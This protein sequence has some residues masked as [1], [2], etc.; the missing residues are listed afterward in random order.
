MAKSVIYDFS[1]TGN[2]LS[3]AKSVERGSAK[4]VR[5][6]K[7]L[8]QQADRVS[9]S[10]T[11]VGKR[12]I[13][14][15]RSL[16]AMSL[17]A[18]ASVVASAKSFGDFESG[19]IDVI[20][21]VDTADVGKFS[22]SLEELSK[23][24]LRMGFVIGDA[25]KGLFD[26]VSAL[27]AGERSF[28][29][30]EAS[31]RLAIA[32]S[33]ELTTAV[34]GMT[35]AVG[36][37]GD[38]AGTST[39]IANAFFAAQV[40]GKLDVAGLAKNIG[41]VGA[42]GKL[43]GFEFRPLLAAVSAIT[44]QGL[45]AEVAATGLASGINALLKPE[46]QAAIL[47][48]QN[49]IAFGASALQR[50]DLV[51]VMERIAQVAKDNPD[52]MAKM[53]PQEALKVM[54]AINTDSLETM[55]EALALMKTNQLGP[56]EA[57]KMDTFN[58]SMKQTF[59]SIKILAITIGSSLAPVIKFFGRVIQ[60]VTAIFDTFSDTTKSVFSF[61]L[62]GAAGLSTLFLVIGKGALV[63]ATWGKVLAGLGNLLGALA[64][65]AKFLFAMLVGFIGFWPAVIALAVAGIVA[66]GVLIHTKGEEMLAFGK[67]IA[68]IFGFGDSS[69]EVAG[70]DALEAQPN[71]EVTGV[72]DIAS[73]TT[74]EGE[75]TVKAEPGTAVTKT[76]S[77]GSGPGLN[78]HPQN[79]GT[80]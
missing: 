36:I 78:T 79:Q 14:L 50:T 20:N 29:V 37:F 60:S 57:K 16:Q 40:K 54:G 71:L 47:M 48:R 68:G 55:A 15:G 80:R 32:G 67:K 30:F 22:G 43:A 46:K 6:F 73:K 74:M 62:V 21:L 24:A 38:E 10:L 7:T 5:Q 70:P 41:K 3:F 53:F 23:D 35:S 65:A 76:K 11:R 26:T 4:V 12:T 33:T 13:G 52:A 66:L 34:N 1:G 28:S 56:A 44:T 72:K 9:A 39:E 58:Q 42:S 75:I 25:N 45:T 59:G 51:T 77:K 8:A 31:Q 49:G 63:M 27:G 69:V 2:F 18:G 61:I 17:V 19:L 64:F